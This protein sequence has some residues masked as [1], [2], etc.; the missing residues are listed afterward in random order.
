M[1]SIPKFGPRE[2]TREQRQ[3]MFDKAAAINATQDRRMEPF[4][5]QLCQRYIDGEVSLK[6]VI[7]Q[8]EEVHQRKYVGQSQAV[9]PVL[10]A[11]LP[12]V[13]TVRQRHLTH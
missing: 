8:V 3:K 2:Q 4:A 5:V 9:E 6:E 12:A 7:A 11:Q 10:T 1:E 13:A